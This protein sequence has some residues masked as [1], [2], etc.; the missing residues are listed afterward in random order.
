MGK[1]Q[2][3]YNQGFWHTFWVDE[4]G[5][6]REAWGAPQDQIGLQIGGFEPNADVSAMRIWPDPSNPFGSWY[7]ISAKV[8]GANGQRSVYWVGG[9]FGQPANHWEGPVDA[10][11][12]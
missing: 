12:A 5:V 3:I 10:I 6:L 8:A 1:P 11:A 4:G 7:A 9:G 2:S